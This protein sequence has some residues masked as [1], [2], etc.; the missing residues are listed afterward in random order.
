[1]TSTT[2]VTSIIGPTVSRSIEY[3]NL[4]KNWWLRSPYTDS[5][6]SALRVHPDGDVVIIYGNVTISFG[7]ESPLTYGVDYAYLVFPSGDVY[8][9]DYLVNYISYGI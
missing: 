3:P 8:D 4:Y 7:R 1:M 2:L 9:Y 5:T 6:V